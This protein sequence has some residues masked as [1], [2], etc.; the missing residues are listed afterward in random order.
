MEEREKFKI[1][2]ITELT[3]GLEEFGKYQF[4]DKGAQEIMDVAAMTSDLLAFSNPDIIW[5]LEEVSTDSDEAEHLVSAMMESLFAAMP[6]NQF[7]ALLI[8]SEILS[9]LF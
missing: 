4:Y 9:D 7:D 6:E 3:Q 8:E 1:R 2:M 5:I